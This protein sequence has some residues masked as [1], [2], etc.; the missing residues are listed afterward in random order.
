M[1]TNAA[2]DAA[3]KAAATSGDTPGSEATS[4][5]APETQSLTP[6][7]LKEYVAKAVS[8]DRT[9]T[10]RAEK[11]LEAKVAAHDARVALFEKT[12]T[13]SRQTRHAAEDAVASTSSNP[14]DALKLLQT[15]RETEQARADAEKAKAELAVI[16]TDK[17]T[18]LAET[19][20]AKHL[21]DL[22]LVAGQHTVPVETLLKHGEGMDITQLHAL[23]AD[24]KG[25]ASSKGP[26]LLGDSGDGTG[27]DGKSGKTVAGM[28]LQKSRSA[29]R[30]A[31][32][33]A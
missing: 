1:A 29:P 10:G 12:E 32:P 19:A 4:S 6:E 13:S 2:T 25:G 26:V 18:A 15:N 5:S 7:E 24:L 28:M 21:S 3:G 22:K 14:E 27:G 9:K 33:V 11:A 31:V 20:E 23:A 17:E 30:P 8:D 16:N